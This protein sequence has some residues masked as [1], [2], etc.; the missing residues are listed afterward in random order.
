MGEHDLPDS[1][2]A[3]RLRRFMKALLAD[4]RALERMIRDGVLETG[5]R[6]IG[7][8]QE[9][10]LVDEAGRPR[11]MALD[12][13]ARL[14]NP[15][16]TTELA[17]F[18]LETNLNPQVF[19][20][21]CLRRMETELR[22]NLLKARAAAE[23][24]GGGILLSG[25]LPTLRKSDLTL[26]AMVPNPRYRQLNDAMA[27]LRGGEFN[28]LIKGIDEL[29]TTHDNVMLESCNTSFQVPF[30]VAPHEFAKLYNVA[31]A[32]TAPVLAAAVNSPILLG[33][34]LWHETRIALFQQS[35][36]ARSKVHQ[37][38][39][40]RAR[41]SFG[42]HWIHDSVMEIFRE[43]IARFRVL[44]AVDSDED[45]EAMLDRG[46]AP[47]LTALR[48]HNGTVYRWNRACYG[49]ANGQAHLR[50]ENRVL[51]AGPTVLDEMA[52]AAFFFGLM[53]ALAEEHDDISRV[54]QF[55]HAKDN[56]HAAARAGLRAQFT[57]IGGSQYTAQDLILTHLLPLARYGL[58]DHGIDTRDVDRY[59]GVLEDRVRSGMTGAQ[60]MLDSLSGM[61]GQGTPDE[62]L[63]ALVQC[64]KERQK[65]GDPIHTWKPA[66]LDDGGGWRHSYLKV[67]D[68]MTTDLFTVHA[69]DV[70]DLA[71][72]LMDWRHIRH[73]PVEDNEGRLVGLI[74]HR[75]LLRLVGQGLSSDQSEHVLVQDVMKRN[76]VTVSP[77]TPT[78]EAIEKMR[79]H[80]VGSLPIVEDG[81][82]V[83]IITERDL[84]N[85]SASLFEQHLREQ[86]QRN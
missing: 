38:R 28:F 63:R 5:V 18:N 14:D 3:V 1:I 53:S 75:S 33:R 26:D 85:V 42:D 64:A 45:P 84:I 50:I 73:V 25:I 83:G 31:Q 79:A 81:K 48:L 23:S 47:P 43:D 70:V 51:P 15:A 36:D 77:D 10:F 55:D 21:D 37:N 59:L 49:V 8:E 52:N 69:G 32:I 66:S 4:V 17:Q 46:E 86:G 19:G 68:F 39:G 56:F 72:S 74:S 65:V 30:Q 20:T 80:R 54:M 78:L 62:R 29:E 34:R 67:G 35:V 2:D 22:E 58:L 11:N 7:A 71:A 16:F 61:Q 27:A 24:A 6:R 40:L 9:M 57:W 13:L 76:V 41:V 44:L 60:W 82:L 12:V